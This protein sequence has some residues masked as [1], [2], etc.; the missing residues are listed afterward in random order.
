MRFHELLVESA[1]PLGS[2]PVANYVIKDQ[3]T[4]RTFVDNDKRWSVR[5][6]DGKIFPDY[7]SAELK[8]AELRKLFP[9]R[10]FFSQE[11]A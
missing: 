11:V 8:I 7:H 6:A 3:K 1:A 5:E 10:R 2:N 4:Y 9:K